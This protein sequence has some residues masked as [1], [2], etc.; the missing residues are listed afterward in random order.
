MGRGEIGNRDA[1]YASNSAFVVVALDAATEWGG[2]SLAVEDADLAAC[3]DDKIN[4]LTDSRRIGYGEWRTNPAVFMER[5]QQ[6][7][8]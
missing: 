5:A 1:S 8:P 6:W 3:I 2:F 7:N 4:Y